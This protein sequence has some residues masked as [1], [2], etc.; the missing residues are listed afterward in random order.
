MQTTGAQASPLAM[1]VASTRKNSSDEIKLNVLRGFCAAK[2]ATHCKRDACAPVGSLA[3]F[4]NM[5]NS[6]VAELYFIG[7]MMIIILIISSVATYLFFRQYKIEMRDKERINAEALKQK[8]AAEKD[9]L[10]E[11]KEISPAN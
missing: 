7:A 3:N 8:E 4:K 9:K 5:S 1:S 11:E 2:N 10:R 6:A